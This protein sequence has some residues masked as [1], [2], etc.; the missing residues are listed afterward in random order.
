LSARVAENRTRRELGYA[1]AKWRAV[2]VAD[3]WMGGWTTKNTAFGKCRNVAE[4]Y[5]PMYENW[6][7][8]CRI[9]RD[10]RNK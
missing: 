4:C 7:R 2:N 10:V 8:H 6:L 3:P 1:A 5:T 9:G